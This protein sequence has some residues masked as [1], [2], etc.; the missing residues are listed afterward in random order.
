M[1]VVAA[2]ARRSAPPRPSFPAT[3]ARRAGRTVA[4]G[5]LVD[6]ASGV[7]LGWEAT[8]RRLDEE[9]RRLE[10][11]ITELEAAL[12]EAN[13]AADRRTPPAASFSPR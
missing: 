12:E 5:A 8:E 3:T 13:E 10:A 2:S 9:Q 7:R 6:G 4:V 11:Q 1:L